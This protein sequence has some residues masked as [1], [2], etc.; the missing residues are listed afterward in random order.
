MVRVEKDDFMEYQ[1]IKD[2]VNLLKEIDDFDE[3]DFRG[4]TEEQIERLEQLLPEYT[5]IPESYYEYLIFGGNGICN[6]LNGTDFYFPQIY[7]L[8]A[9]QKIIHLKDTNFFAPHFD[10]ESDLT[11]QLFLFYFHQGYFARFFYLDA[12]DDPNI[13][14]YEA[15]L[16]YKFILTQEQTFSEYLYS[17]VSNFIAQYQEIIATI[18]IGLRNRV[19]N[20]RQGILGI[21]DRLENFP[22]TVDREFVEKAVKNYL[23]ILRKTYS[24]LFEYRFYTVYQYEYVFSPTINLSYVESEAQKVQEL[25]KTI[26]ELEDE[27]KEL[28]SYIKELKSK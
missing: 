3:R 8:R 2:S 18:D 26:S 15:G 7:T 27:G 21:L 5:Y 24:L 14:Y 20:Y 28:I 19:K 9:E 25:T 13:Y 10:V 6:M 17:E 4:C 1:F 22:D 16:K 11:D 23:A 12:G